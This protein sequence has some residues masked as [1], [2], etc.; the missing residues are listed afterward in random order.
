MRV[1]NGY[2]TAFLAFLCFGVV[3]LNVAL[4]VSGGASK[5]ELFVV[6]AGALVLGLL[7]PGSKEKTES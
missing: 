7:F 3:A 5:R 2:V 4:L 1:V 6:V